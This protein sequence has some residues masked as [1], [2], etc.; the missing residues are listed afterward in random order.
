MRI[1]ILAPTDAKPFLHIQRAH[2]RKILWKAADQ[3]GPPTVNIEKFGWNV[4][5]KTPS[6]TLTTIPPAPLGL[7]DALRCGCKA[8]GKTCTYTTC[9]CHKNKIPCSV[10]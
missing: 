2:L 6:P 8:E 10:Y 1:M 7:I 5:D 3:S 4:K 9:S